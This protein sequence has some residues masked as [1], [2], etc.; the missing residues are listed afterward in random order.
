MYRRQAEQLCVPAVRP[1][2]PC[3]EGKLSSSLFKL[4]FPLFYIQKASPDKLTKSAFLILTQEIKH[5]IIYW[6]MN[7]PP[8]ARLVTNS[9]RLMAHLDSTFCPLCSSIHRPRKIYSTNKITT[10][11]WLQEL[12]LDH[13]TA[14]SW[15]PFVLHPMTLWHENPISWQPYSELAR[16][17]TD[18]AP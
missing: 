10:L 9:H 6:W 13:S 8:S 12:N 4:S 17:H 1:P 14:S 5:V 3:I 2:F 7:I 18:S 16:I 11:Q 15:P